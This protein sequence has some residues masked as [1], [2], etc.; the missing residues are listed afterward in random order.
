MCQGVQNEEGAHF[1]PTC[2]VDILLKAPMILEIAEEHTVYKSGRVSHFSPF[3]A[4][5]DPEIVASQFEKSWKSAGPCPEVRA[6]Y[7]IVSTKL[8]LD[9]Y[10]DYKSDPHP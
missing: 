3:D 2:E 6:V 8:S 4:L 1:C 7:K 10:E 9:E 5:A